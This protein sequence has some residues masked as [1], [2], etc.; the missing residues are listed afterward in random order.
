MT[1]TCI[2]E[3]EFDKYLLVNKNCKRTDNVESFGGNFTV[4][5]TMNRHFMGKAAKIVLVYSMKTHKF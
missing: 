2:L 4:W 1:A 5:V 3:P